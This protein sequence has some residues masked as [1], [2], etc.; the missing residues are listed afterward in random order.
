M[1]KT[2]AE[3]LPMIVNATTEAEAIEVLEETLKALCLTSSYSELIKLKNTLDDHKRDFRRISDEYRSL[4]VPRSHLNIQHYRTELNFLYRDIVDDIVFDINRLKIHFE[5]YKTVQRAESL[6]SLK[7][8]KSIIQKFGRGDKPLSTSALRE[9]L[10]ADANYR[11]Y[12]HLASTSY[13]LYQEVAKVLDSIKSMS[14]T[15]ASEL[16][17]TTEINLKDVK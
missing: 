13:G 12:V 8:N 3:L 15:M 1:R 10:G 4:S 9:I 11:E 17:N 6:S 2:S 16:R 7:E 14:D 5:E